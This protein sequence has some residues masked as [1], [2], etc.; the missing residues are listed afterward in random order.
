MLKEK[1]V[2]FGKDIKNFYNWV[3]DEIR[4]KSDK[5]NK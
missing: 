5:I 4:N 2:I 3:L 1:N